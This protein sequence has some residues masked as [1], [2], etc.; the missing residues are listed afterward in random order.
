MNLNNLLTEYCS[1][2]FFRES[3]HRR[4]SGR[5]WKME[6]E[7]D[8]SPLITPCESRPAHRAPGFPRPQTG[9]AMGGH[10]SSTLAFGE[11]MVVEPQF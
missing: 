2:S 6:N 1:C 4:C 10:P 9:T 5:C 8:S 11:H 3:A 7:L